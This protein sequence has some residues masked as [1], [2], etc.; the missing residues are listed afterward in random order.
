MQADISRGSDTQQRH[1]SSQRLLRESP[2]EE[3]KEALHKSKPVIASAAKQSI[4]AC[5]SN[6]YGSPRRCA[7]RDDGLMQTFPKFFGVLRHTFNKNSLMS[8]NNA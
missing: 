4:F 6:T 1:A 5:Q 3:T 7:P 8:N 2:I